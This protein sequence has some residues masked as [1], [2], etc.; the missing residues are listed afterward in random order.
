MMDFVSASLFV[1]VERSAVI[2]GRC[3]CKN[4][5]GGEGETHVCE[6]TQ[7]Y[8]WMTVS[9]IVVIGVN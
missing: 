7:L 4:G 9:V 6:I 3:G 5:K 8:D 1:F 2:R